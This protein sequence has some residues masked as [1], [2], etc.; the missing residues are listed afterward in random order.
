MARLSAAK[1]AKA[2]NYHDSILSARR[3]DFFYHV[4]ES[5]QQWNLTQTRTETELR[6]QRDASTLQAERLQ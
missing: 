2:R 6:A 5:T 1:S 3:R 4:R